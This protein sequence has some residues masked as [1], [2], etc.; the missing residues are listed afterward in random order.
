MVLQGGVRQAT[1]APKYVYDFQLFDKV[2]YEGQEC[3]IFG[4]RVSGYFDLR[5]LDRTKVRSHARC[6]VL[7]LL[8]RS[9][10]LLCERRVA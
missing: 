6:G 9:N 3:F 4:R 1:K 5:R 2:L 8:N 7:R 10:T